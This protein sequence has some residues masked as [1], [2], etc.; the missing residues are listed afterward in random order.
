MNDKKTPTFIPNTTG[1]VALLH[2][3]KQIRREAVQS[4]YEN[5]TFTFTEARAG[6]EWIGTMFFRQ[7]QA[8]SL[9][10]DIHF[11]TAA[12]CAGIK[13]HYPQARARFELSEF[14]ADLKR[15]GIELKAGVLKGSSWAQDGSKVWSSSLKYKGF[16]V[17]PS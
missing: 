17:F 16:Y 11:D 7:P 13:S 10:S 9:I 3:C 1:N 6:F 15:C 8:L 2:S 5:T 14:V 12:F 4:Y